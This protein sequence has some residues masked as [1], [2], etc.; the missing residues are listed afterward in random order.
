MFTLSQTDTFPQALRFVTPQRDIKLGV[1]MTAEQ[2]QVVRRRLYAT[3]PAL[4]LLAQAEQLQ[5]VNSPSR[6]SN[7]RSW[8]RIAAIRGATLPVELTTE[9]VRAIVD[10]VVYGVCDG[11]TD[12]GFWDERERRPGMEAPYVLFQQD[13]EFYQDVLPA[14][15]QEDWVGS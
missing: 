2:F 8:F 9:D 12:A 14:E 13:P 7:V 3:Y 10:E 1:H 15:Q 6:F 5:M 11:F 4:W